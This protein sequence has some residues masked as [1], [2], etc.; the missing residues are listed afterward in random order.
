MKV[1]KIDDAI[2]MTR[3]ADVAIAVNILVNIFRQYRLLQ[4]V[5]TEKLHPE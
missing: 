3:Y 1:R 2:R 4:A 5:A